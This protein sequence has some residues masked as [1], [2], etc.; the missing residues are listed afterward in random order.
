[1][2]SLDGS[3]FKFGR[4]RVI[5]T[6]NRGQDPYSVNLTFSLGIRI[7]EE[8]SRVIIPLRSCRLQWS[9]LLLRRTCVKCIVTVF[10][11]TYILLFR[12]SVSLYIYIVILYIYIVSCFLINK[13][14][15]VLRIFR[16]SENIKCYN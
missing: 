1:M 14:S 10:N 3:A 9:R 6:V 7:R 8:V 4:G 2:M 11:H 16:F 12:Y 5:Q 15:L 13:A